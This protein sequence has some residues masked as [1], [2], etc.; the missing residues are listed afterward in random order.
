MSEQ[1]ATIGPV[2]GRIPSGI[3]ILSARGPAGEQTGMLA[4]WVQQASFEPAAV[5]VAVNN[6]RYINDWLQTDANVGLSL[7][8]ESQK[9]LLSHFGKGFEPGQPAFEGLATATTPAGITVL[10]NAMGWLAG[11]VVNSVNAGDHTVYVVQLTHGSPAATIETE[12]PFVH[13]RKNG[14]GY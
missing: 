1:Q 8:G 10:A 11:Q 12:K 3:V 14:F 6:K 5:S 2:L 4:S 9:N 13:I 7:V